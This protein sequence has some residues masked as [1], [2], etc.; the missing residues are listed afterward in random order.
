MIIEPYLLHVL[1]EEYHQIK[2]KVL[3]VNLN[4]KFEYM[5]GV[6]E[7]IKSGGYNF[8]WYW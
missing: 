2:F 5:Y 1:M 6:S 8:E 7:L 3:L 4:N